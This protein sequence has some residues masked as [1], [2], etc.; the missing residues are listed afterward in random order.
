MQNPPA[1]QDNDWNILKLL[2]W[3]T[4]YFTSRSIENPRAGAEILLASVL[5]LERVDLY[6]RYDQP[7]SAEELSRF[8]ELIRRRCAGEPVAYIV[9]RREFWSMDFT[10]TPDVLIPRP[11][12]EC[13]V[14]AVLH[15]LEGAAPGRRIIDLGTGCGAV[16]LALAARMPQHL[17]WASDVSAA[18][19]AVARQNARAHRLSE[20]VRFFCGSWLEPVQDRSARFDMIVSNPPYVRRSAIENLQVEIRQY[21]P[22]SALDGGEDGLRCLKAIVAS[23]A[24]CLKAGG[25]LLLE[26]GFDQKEALSAV[27][28]RTGAYHDVTFLKDYGGRDRVAA[29]QKAIK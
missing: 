8:K 29:L 7:L 6:V 17:F 14:E 3:T 26:I 16:A 15:R 24:G 28:H 4:A 23:A 18:A 27:V 10:V 5:Q 20:N 19:L 12:T 2:Q 9:G 13:L 21:E 22:L 25:H 11:E 1:S